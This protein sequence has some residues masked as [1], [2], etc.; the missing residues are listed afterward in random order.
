MVLMRRYIFVNDDTQTTIADET[1]RDIS[2]AFSM[3]TE[4]TFFKEK[5]YMAYIAFCHVELNLSEVCCQIGF[6]QMCF[7]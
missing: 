1:C 7:F 6:F 5:S 3:D 2:K 4:H